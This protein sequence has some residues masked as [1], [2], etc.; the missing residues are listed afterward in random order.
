MSKETRAARRAATKEDKA[1]FRRADRALQ[2]NSARERKAG[3]REETAE[4]HR[5]NSE[6]DRLGR[7]IGK[8]R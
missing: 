8:W 3:I 5:L 6:V 1:A 4:F 7:K 2:A